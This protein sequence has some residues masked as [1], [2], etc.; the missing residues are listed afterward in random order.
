MD[1]YAIRNLAPKKQP[2]PPNTETKSPVLKLLKKTAS[3]ANIAP[4]TIED[5][6]DFGTNH[7]DESEQNKVCTLSPSTAFEFK[8]GSKFGDY[9]IGGIVRVRQ[10]KLVILDCVSGKM[11]MFKRAANKKNELQFSCITTYSLSDHSNGI[12]AVKED[13]LAVTS[14]KKVQFFKVRRSRL[15]CTTTTIKTPSKCFAIAASSTKVFFIAQISSK[16]GCIKCYERTKGTFQSTWK[17]DFIIERPFGENV[18][19]HSSM[20]AEEREATVYFTDPFN[21]FLAS[22]SF[23]GEMI[24]I[25]RFDWTPRGL[26]VVD[27]FIVVDNDTARSLCLMNKNGQL[28]KTLISNLHENPSHLCYN[29]ISRELFVCALRSQKIRVYSVESLDTAMATS[30]C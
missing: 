18:S 11:K 28:L 20:V 30:E 2:K 4:M 8:L 24:R 3:R 13:M 7:Q 16:Y 21:K 17:L 6:E 1:S 25:A 12:A 19:I 22:M 29:P 26:A 15:K 5:L 14:E 27:D 9:N 10:E 23:R